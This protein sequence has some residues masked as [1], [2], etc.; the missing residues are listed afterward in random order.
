MMIVIIMNM[1]KVGRGNVTIYSEDD[2]NLSTGRDIARHFNLVLY[3]VLVGN[4]ANE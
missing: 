2:G 1:A 3:W 4:V